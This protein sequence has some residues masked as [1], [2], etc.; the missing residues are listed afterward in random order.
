[1]TCIIAL[2]D[3]RHVFMGADTLAVDEATAHPMRQ[4]KI[5]RRGEFLFGVSGTMRTGQLLEH[6][7]EVP[8]IEKGQD[9]LTYMVGTFVPRYRDC[10][11]EAEYL[12]MKEGQATNPDDVIVAVR[13]RL[14][15][16]DGNF[17]VYE[18]RA[19][20]LVI[21]SGQDV[22]RG[23]LF[24]TGHMEPKKRIERALEAAAEFNVGV[25]GP[26]GIISD[27]GEM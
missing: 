8:P 16:V 11:K 3:D 23:A 21:G 9:L 4:D 24:V 25:R 5:F 10:L 1:M 20:Y 12:I 7:F 15:V 14:F 6:Q 26:F 17:S 13:R 19:N 22:A 18:P 27:E 2:Q